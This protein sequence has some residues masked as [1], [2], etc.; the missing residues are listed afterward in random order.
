MRTVLSAICIF[1]TSIVFAQRE[2]ATSA[3]TERLKSL[4]PSLT[5]RIVS[6]ENFISLQKSQRDLGN[7]ETTV[8]KIPVVVHVLYNN[9]AENISDDQIKSQIIA[10]NRDFRRNNADS[11]NTPDRFKDVAADVQVEFALATADAKGAATTGIVRKQTGAK[12]FTNDD[13]I[14]FSFQGGDD[15]WDSRYYLNIWVGDLSTLL[16]YSSIPGAAAN[17]DGVVINYT[18][19][20]TINVGSPY[21]MGRTAVH[22]VGHWLGL[23]HI[24]GD[25]YCGDDLVGDTPKQGNFTTGCPN[26]FRSSCDNGDLGD[27]YMN[28]MDYTN[29]ACMNLFTQGQKQRMLSLF[30]TGGPRSL[31]LSSRG[32]DAPWTVE[33]P[34]DQPLST[35]FKFYPNPTNGD[36]V[37]N[38]EYN[39]DWIGK[40]V[41]VININGVT[42]SKLQINSKTQKANLSE[43]KPG[44]YFIKGENGNEKVVA[45]FIKL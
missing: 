8:I 35:A 44:M 27:M 3:Y 40:T 20:G 28:Y 45:K 4:D 14:K 42:V 15:A 21:N 6:I 37:L 38:F 7:G 12:Y 29:D 16:G 43:L 2:C 9:A 25:T 33:S 17:V 22:E 1:I 18:A 39:A 36:L 24:W 32:L 34:I 19:F 31:I 10:L 30:S 23:K 13:K 26:T 41:S 11:V 5:N